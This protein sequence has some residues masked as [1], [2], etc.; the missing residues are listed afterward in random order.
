MAAGG[1]VDCILLAAGL[2]RRMGRWKMALPWGGGHGP[3]E[4]RARG[5]AGRR[6]A[7][8]LAGRILAHPATGTLREVLAGVAFEEV[9]VD[10][11]GILQDLDDERDYRE[12]GG[13]P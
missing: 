7:G 10:D 1:S 13:K 6:P 4:R 12:L 5:A 3:V 8:T 2:S 9:A 11:P